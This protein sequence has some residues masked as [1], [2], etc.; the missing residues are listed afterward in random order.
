[1]TDDNFYSNLQEF[2]NDPKYL[3]EFFRRNNYIFT[4]H[5]ITWEIE[6]KKKNLHTYDK[7]SEYKNVYD[8]IEDFKNTNNSF[9]F[10]LY[11]M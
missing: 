1:M 8:S 10:P 3:L 11:S 9:S 2:N 4:S 7:Y 6:N 5:F